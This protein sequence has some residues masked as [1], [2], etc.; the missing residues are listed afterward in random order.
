[1]VKSGIVNTETNRHQD[2][3]TFF[4]TKWD[5]FPDY[6]K[7]SIENVK[8]ISIFLGF[9]ECETNATNKRKEKKNTE[10]GSVR[11]SLNRKNKQ[12]FVAL[13]VSNLS[14]YT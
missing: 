12:Q 7:E 1:M 9:G 13:Y 14:L 11:E 10:I 4:F 5:F 2:H 8:I 3:D 6:V